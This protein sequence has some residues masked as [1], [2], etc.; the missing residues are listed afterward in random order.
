MPDLSTYAGKGWR[1]LPM[2]SGKFTAEN[3]VHQLNIPA[4]F[5]YTGIYDNNLT[6]LSYPLFG[7]ELQDDGSFVWQANFHPNDPQ[8]WLDAEHEVGPAVLQLFELG[9][10]HWKGERQLMHVRVASWAQLI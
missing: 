7:T 5:V 10:T 6:S 2:W 8:P 1:A 4:T 3:Y 9:P